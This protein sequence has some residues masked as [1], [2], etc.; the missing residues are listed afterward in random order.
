[1]KRVVLLLTL[2]IATAMAQPA[3]TQQRNK[4][5]RSDEIDDRA[6]ATLTR[7]SDYLKTLK[8]FRINSEISQDQIVDTNMK[9]QKNGTNETFVR[10]PDRL[11]THLETDDHD[12]E[13]IYDG[14]TFTLFGVG[15]NFYA[16]SPAPPTISRTLNAVRAKYGIV[17]PLADFI[18]MAGDENL[19]QEVTMVGYIGT[20]RIDGV[21]CDHLAIRQT[22]VDWQVW[23]EKGDKP[24]P[25]RVVITTKTQP[26]QPQFM[27]TLRWDLSPTIDDNMFSFTPPTD[28]VRIRF[29]RKTEKK[30]TP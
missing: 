7:M 5:S 27:T 26:T 21:E 1:M 3:S 23:I 28:A 15:Q 29:G 11:H 10:M 24:L 12:L 13:F 9:V 22:E 14:K 17:F 6:M 2:S 25:R 19:L 20:S 16:S 18:Q 4:P 8:T 30:V